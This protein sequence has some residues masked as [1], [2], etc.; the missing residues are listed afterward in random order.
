MVAG[1]CLLERGNAKT[2]NVSL[3][4]QTQQ[5]RKKG[6]AGGVQVRISTG[7]VVGGLALENPP[8]RGVA[9]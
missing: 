5:Y 3:V 4:K 2:L 7:S 1:Q 9:Q 8:S 6:C